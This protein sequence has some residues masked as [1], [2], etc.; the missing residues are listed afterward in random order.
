M[1]VTPIPEQYTTITP[2]LITPRLAELLDY[3]DRAFDA[4]IE[5]KLDRPDGSVMHAEIQIGDSMVM[6]GEPMGEFPASSSNIF[7]YVEDCDAAFDKAV[8]AGGT[9]AMPVTTMEH[10]GHRY[11]GVQDPS[12]NVWWIGSRIESVSWE[13]QQYRIDAVADQGAGTE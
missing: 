4:R 13:E 8:E 10:A 2:Y 5:G 6:L 11:G 1:S 7:V 3:L 9:V 12:G